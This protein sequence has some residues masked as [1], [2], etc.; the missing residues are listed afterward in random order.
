M[1]LEHEAGNSSRLVLQIIERTTDQ[2]VNRNAPDLC[3]GCIRFRSRSLY[4]GIFS[5]F[6]VCPGKYWNST[7]EQDMPTPL[8]IITYLPSTFPKLSSAAHIYDSAV[9][10][11]LPLLSY[12]PFLFIRVTHCTILGKHEETFC[13]LLQSFR[14]V[15][16]NSNIL[17]VTLFHKG[18]SQFTRTT[19]YITKNIVTAK[20]EKSYERD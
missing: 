18:A 12:F 17:F 11:R 7:S 4:C 2:A 20:W 14:I 13:L 9:C 8:H 16:L 6:H 1:Q 15:I 5:S 3:F 19:K 10:L